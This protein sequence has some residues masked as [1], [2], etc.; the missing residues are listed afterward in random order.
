MFEF[1][2]IND[3]F[4]LRNQLVNDMETAVLRDTHCGKIL[5]QYYS[6]RDAGYTGRDHAFYHHSLF[7][8]ECLGK[9]SC[10]DGIHIPRAPYY[11]LQITG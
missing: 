9:H 6:Q 10:K 4:V 3:H 1:T 5:R 2:T 11:L 7:L 8:R